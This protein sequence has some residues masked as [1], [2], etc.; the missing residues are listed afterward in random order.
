MLDIKTFQFTEHGFEQ[1]KKYRY[2]I[3]WPVVYISENKKEVYIGET[4]NVYE[5][6]KQHYKNPERRRLTSIHVLTDE[7]F[8]KSAALDIESLFIQFMSADGKY[9]L[10][11][12]NSGLK[13]HNYY[14]RVKYKTKFELT[15][16]K[17]KE[18]GLVNSTLNELKNSVLFK[19]SPYKALSPDQYRIAELLVGAIQNN[20]TNTCIINGKPGT[21]KTILATYLIKFLKENSKTKN[22]KIVLLIPMTS[23]RKTIKKVFRNIKGLSS[24]MVIGPNDV[25]KQ[26]YDLVIVDE[27][28]RLRRRKN[29]TNY[30]AFDQIN[31][32]LGLDKNGNELDWIMK[33]SNHQ[34]FFYDSNQSIRPSDIRAEDFDKINAKHYDLISQLRVK[35]GTDYIDFIDNIFNYKVPVKKSFSNYDFKI[36]DNANSMVKDIKKRNMKYGLSRIVAGYAWPW[37]TNP[38]KKDKQTQGHDIEIGNLRLIWNSSAHDWVNSKNAINEVGCIHTVQGY[39]LNYVG[40]I[41]GPEFKYNAKTGKFMVDR[42]KYFDINGRNGINDLTELEQYIINIYKTLC[43]RGIRGT[44]IYIVNEELR[45]YFKKITKDKENDF[46]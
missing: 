31:N 43:T 16:E 18:E 32:K 41:I 36:Y 33:F 3:D 15:W 35:A 30:A 2:G 44:Y 20:T 45:E 26:E 5:R 42:T 40:V 46:K 27:A 12:G 14:N 21:G 29:I 7:E 8:N 25:V 17:L 39:D 28:H 4:I 19:Y 6:S 37:H 1:I 22:L 13:N 9:I 34:I 24:S 38:K 23:L 11:N 10:Q